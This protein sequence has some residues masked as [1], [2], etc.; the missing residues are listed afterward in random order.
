MIYKDMKH[1]STAAKDTLK[2]ARDF[3]ASKLEKFEIEK[4]ILAIDRIGQTIA[5]GS[6]IDKVFEQKG[7]YSLCEISLFSS[8]KKNGLRAVE[9]AYYEYTMRIKNCSTEED[10]MYIL[11]GINTRLNILEDYLN[12]TPDLSDFERKKWTEL[13]YRYRALREELA[14]KK[15]WNKNNYGI[16]INYD[17]LDKLEEE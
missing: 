8:L 11:R 6:R 1:N 2:D 3:T 16:F 4:T 17:E 9:D 13:A 14:K 7:M 5:E 12:N 15:I 10:A